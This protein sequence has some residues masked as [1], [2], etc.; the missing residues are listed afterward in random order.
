MRRTQNLMLQQVV[1]IVTTV[2]N[3]LHFKQEVR[4]LQAHGGACRSI[5]AV[6]QLVHCFQ[7][8]RQLRPI[9]CREAVIGAAGDK[10][11]FATLFIDFQAHE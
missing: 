4:Q 2:L 10:R 7:P 8:E 5:R 9:Y 3:W 6:L 11:G 1:H